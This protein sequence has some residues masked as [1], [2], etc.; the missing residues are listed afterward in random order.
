[1]HHTLREAAQT[2]KDSSLF[3]INVF[4]QFFLMYLVPAVVGL[5][6]G[7]MK[8]TTSLLLPNGMMYT[9]ISSPGLT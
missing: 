1:M 2:S 5:I 8:T 3:K 4:L 9:H 6:F 7:T